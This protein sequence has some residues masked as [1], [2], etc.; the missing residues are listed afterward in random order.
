MRQAF[1]GAQNLAREIH[2]FLVTTLSGFI[3]DGFEVIFIGLII[4]VSLRLE[5]VVEAEE[6]RIVSILFLHELD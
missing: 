5:Q 1:L 3:E 4:A 2:G 6:K